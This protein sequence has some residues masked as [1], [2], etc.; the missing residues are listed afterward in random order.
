MADEDFKT[1]LKHAQSSLKYH[2]DLPQELQS[3]EEVFEL[4]HI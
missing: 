2:M 4:H 1:A 3:K